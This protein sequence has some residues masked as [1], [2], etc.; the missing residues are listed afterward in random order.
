MASAAATDLSGFVLVPIE[1]LRAL[2]ALETELP[3]IIN[4]AKQEEKKER[5]AKL[6]ERD[7]EVH[8][9]HML[10]YYHEHKEEINAKRRERRLKKKEAEL[11]TPAGSPGRGFGS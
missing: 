6:H 2:E 9:K 3:S 10:E 4:K 7:P 5:L 1:R 8:R 11:G